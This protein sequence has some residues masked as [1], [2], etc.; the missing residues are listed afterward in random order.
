MVP[1][2]V[3]CVFVCVTPAAAWRRFKFITT[4]DWKR[5]TQ[6]LNMRKLGFRRDD[7]EFALETAAKMDGEL[8]RCVLTVCCS[9]WSRGVGTSPHADVVFDVR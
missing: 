9:W 2:D 6:I 7:I 5:E 8:M 4:V 3:A 1:G